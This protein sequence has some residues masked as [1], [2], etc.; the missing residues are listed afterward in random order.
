MHRKHL[1]LSGFMASGTTTAG[2]LIAARA[3]VPF[4]DL[5]EAV[6]AAASAEGAATASTASIAAL[7]A[8]LGE[9][10]FR[11][12]ETQALASALAAT[13]PSVI[14]AGGGALVDP[15]N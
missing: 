10:A 14:A 6:L 11:R 7:F 3:G 5:D 8:A 9:P 2:R 4:V 15:A 13:P 12:L 1:V